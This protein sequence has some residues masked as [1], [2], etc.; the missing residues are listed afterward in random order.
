LIAKKKFRKK[1]RLNER[2]SLGLLL[3]SLQPKIELNRFERR[4]MKKKYQL[5]GIEETR[6]WS[7]EVQAKTKK[8]FGIFAFDPES[9][10]RVCELTP[11]YCMMRLGVHTLANFQDFND[12]E[13]DS[14]LSALDEG[15]AEA[16]EVEY[17]S[18]PSMRRVLDQN[19]FQA[20]AEVDLQ[21]EEDG[22]ED[23]IFNS[24]FDQ[25]RELYATGSLSAIHSAAPT[26]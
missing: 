17:T 18:I 6:F 9:V 10:T 11:S 22:S 7:E 19:G 16:N 20:L 5:I 4:A 25:L 3:Q 1:G 14:F 15:N 21:E 8:I 13:L 12:E 26:I 24:R 2:R 23:E